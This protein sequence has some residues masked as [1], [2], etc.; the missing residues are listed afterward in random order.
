MS[1]FAMGA[2][3]PGDPAPVYDLYGVVNHHGG[4]LGGHYTSYARCADLTVPFKNEVGE[5]SVCLC[6]LK[7]KSIEIWSLALGA[8][9]V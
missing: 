7:L 6:M 9:F 8:M 5:L 1:R 4:I 3:R 2:H